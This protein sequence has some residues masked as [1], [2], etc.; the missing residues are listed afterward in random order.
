M[1]SPN[2]I[3]QTRLY[4]R[5]LVKLA[6]KAY[7]LSMLTE[8]MVWHY[9][10]FDRLSWNNSWSVPAG[11]QAAYSALL[12]GGCNHTA[13]VLGH[14][15]Q[16]ILISTHRC[17]PTLSSIRRTKLF[18]KLFRL[19]TQCY[20]SSGG[21]KRM[22]A[23]SHNIFLDMWERMLFATVRHKMVGKVVEYRAH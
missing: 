11:Q 3:F 17:F 1:D 9:M 18:R 19:L 13:H 21:L 10:V 2:W 14:S 20:C 23:S 5:R 7:Y 15:N 22:N 16:T 4:D 12:R 8:A 6:E